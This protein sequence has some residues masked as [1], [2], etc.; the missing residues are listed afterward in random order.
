MAGQDIGGRHVIKLRSASRGLVDAEFRIR[1]DT[2]ELW[3]QDRCQAVMDR[4]IFRIWLER[5]PGPYAVDDV[6]WT[7][8]EV[9]TVLLVIRNCGCWVIPE[10]MM[11]GLRARV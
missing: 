3:Y 6:M 9:E 10:H 8:T 7:L 5:S 11:D 2:V 1:R 4:A